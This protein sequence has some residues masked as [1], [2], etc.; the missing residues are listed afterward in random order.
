HQALLLALSEASDAAVQATVAAGQ[1]P[2]IMLDRPLLAR[3]LMEHHLGVRNYTAEV[4]L[5]DPDF[6]RALG[7]QDS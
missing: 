5:A 3:R 1:T 7:T 6:F 4:V 2:V